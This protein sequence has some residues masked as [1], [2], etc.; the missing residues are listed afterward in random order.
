MA[1]TVRVNQPAIQSMFVEGGDIH[2]FAKKLRKDVRIQSRRAAP[3]RTGTLR[4]SITADRIGTNQ[5]RCNFRVYSWAPHARWVEKGTAFVIHPHGGGLVLYQDGRAAPARWAYSEL[6]V[7]DFVLGQKPN[8]F[9]EIGLA[10]A[11][12]LHGLF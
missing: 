3:R 5:Y 9:L 11:F 6:S 4:R 1:T 7:M 10:R 8:P 2:G 12:A